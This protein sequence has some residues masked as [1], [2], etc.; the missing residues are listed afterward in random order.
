M[1][2]LGRAPRA[3]THREPDTPGRRQ[4]QIRKRGK[5]KEKGRKEKAKGNKRTK[6]RQPEPRES[7]ANKK[8]NQ[9]S[10][11]KGEAHQSAPRRTARPTWSNR[12]STGA[13]SWYPGVVSSDLQAEALTCTLNSCGAPANEPVARWTVQETGRVSD[14]VNTRQ[15]TAAHTARDR[16]Q[17]RR[18]EKAHSPVPERV[19]R[20][21]S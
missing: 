7:Q 9:N 19:Q 2:N 13:N 3:K 12:A 17:R 18:Q 20:G 14:W 21:A 5:K 6:T 11:S 8:D 4:K 10:Q 1:F 16:R 15:A